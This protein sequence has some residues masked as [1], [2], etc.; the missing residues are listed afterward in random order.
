MPCCTL[1]L[2]VAMWVRRGSQRLST[3]K[4]T[5]PLI[6]GRGVADADLLS[7]QSSFFYHRITIDLVPAKSLSS[8]NLYTGDGNITKS[9]A[10][11]RFAAD[12]TWGRLQL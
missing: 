12:V 3:G 2:H 9:D 10:D 1:A 7:S 11:F 4:A 6:L 8:V 5:S